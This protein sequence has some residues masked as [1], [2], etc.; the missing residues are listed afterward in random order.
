MNLHDFLDN[1]EETEK[2]AFQVTDDASANWALRKIKQ[3]QEQQKENNALAESEIEKVNAWLSAENGQAQQSIDY[4]QSLLAV[5]AL[6]EREKNPKFKSMKLPNGTVRFRK[7][8]P[9]FKYDDTKLVEYLEKAEE[10][11]LIKIKKEPNKAEVK[12]LFVVLNGKLINPVTGELVEG[13]TIEERE[14]KFEV[15]TE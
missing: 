9:S 6:K 1:Q 11:D 4:F 7:Q 3:H 8:Q 5:Y 14:D 12:K 13:V 15:V 2:E 10:T